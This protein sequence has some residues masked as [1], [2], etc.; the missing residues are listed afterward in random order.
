MVRDGWDPC[1]VPLSGGKGKKSHAV[2]SSAWPLN[3]HNYSENYPKQKQNNKEFEEI[4]EY[5]KQFIH[6]FDEHYLQFIHPFDEH[7]LQ[8]IHQF[9]E[10]YLQFIM[11]RISVLVR[12]V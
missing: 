7:Y 6:P 5:Y 10:H 4:N 2:E 11:I 8:F 12:N 9:D 1:T 3:S